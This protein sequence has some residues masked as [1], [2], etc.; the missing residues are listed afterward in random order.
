MAHSWTQVTARDGNRLII[1]I[2]EDEV[3]TS[4][5]W[6]PIRVPPGCRHKRTKATLVSGTATTIASTIG[7]RPSFTASTQ[8]EELSVSTPAAH[9]DDSTEFDCGF[10]YGKMYGRSTPDSGSDNVV[11]TE[12]ILEVV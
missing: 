4:S 10:P 1:T 2:Q 3:G 6:G 11:T 8:G 12:I 9:I 7:N 5:E